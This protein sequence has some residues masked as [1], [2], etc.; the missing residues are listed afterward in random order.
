MS[1]WTV[2]YVF[3][4]VYYIVEKVLYLLTLTHI[5]MRV[6]RGYFLFQWLF[7]DVVSRDNK[8]PNPTSSCWLHH[9]G[10]DLVQFCNSFLLFYFIFY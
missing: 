7:Y 3:L 5:G 6:N 1:S 10:F 4:L 9:A 2:I 8:Q